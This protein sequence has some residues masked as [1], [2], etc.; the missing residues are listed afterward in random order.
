[1]RLK[2]PEEIQKEKEKQERRI[3]KKY[4]IA[5]IISSAAVLF[6]LITFILNVL[7]YKR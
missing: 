4:N 5:L 1:M 6:N 3:K 2:T 7:Q